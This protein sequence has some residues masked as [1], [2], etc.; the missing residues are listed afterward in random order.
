[1]GYGLSE[2]RMDADYSLGGGPFSIGREKAEVEDGMVID[3]DFVTVSGA[4]F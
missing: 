3:H 1:M 4:T 2:T